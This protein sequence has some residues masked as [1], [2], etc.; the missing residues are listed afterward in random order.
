MPQPEGPRRVRNSPA[1]RHVEGA[2]VDRDHIAVRLSDV[3]KRHGARRRLRR[4]NPC[5]S[6]G[7]GAKARARWISPPICPR[8]VLRH[9]SRKSPS[10]GPER[11]RECRWPV[12]LEEEMACPGKAVSGDGCCPQERRRNDNTGGDGGEDEASSPRNGDAVR[13]GVDAGRRKNGQEPSSYDF[14]R[15]WSARSHL[16]SIIAPRAAR[17]NA[18]RGSRLDLGGPTTY[19]AARFL[20]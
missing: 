1:A 15:G 10:Q 18:P 20:E 7:S 5:R 14:N 13:S 8:S 19:A 3:A 16:D 17:R 11:I 4:H 9:T 6:L 12:L 2:V